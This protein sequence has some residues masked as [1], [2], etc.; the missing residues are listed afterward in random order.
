MG[1]WSIR[2]LKDFLTSRGV[3]VS[4]FSEKRELAAEARDAQA[5]AEAKLELTLSTELRVL[6]PVGATA[7]PAV[8]GSMD[9]ALLPTNITISSVAAAPELGTFFFEPP[10]IPPLPSHVAPAP[11]HGEGA[12]S[13]L[14]HTFGEMMLPPLV[15]SSLIV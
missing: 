8:L 5:L 4:H 10:G 12:S 3:D 13:R 9:T 15:S 11:P 1:A 2:Q 7:A 6:A 14:L